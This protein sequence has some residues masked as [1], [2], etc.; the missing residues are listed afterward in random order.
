MCTM[1]SNC[2]HELRS[3]YNTSMRTKIDRLMY[4]LGRTVL[5]VGL[6][7]GWD[8]S[9]IGMGIRIGLGWD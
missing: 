6:E 3:I 8:G 5:E 4:E 1:I 2:K 9:G 7:V